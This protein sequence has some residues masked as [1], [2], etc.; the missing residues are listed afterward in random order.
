[1]TTAGLRGVGD[2]WLAG[3][4]VPGVEFAL[5]DRVE[6]TAGRHAGALG[7]VALLTLLHPEP[8]Y[9]VALGDGTSVRARQSA[10]RAAS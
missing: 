6:I 9:L 7:G 10:L 5:H 1:M 2:R 4:P 8:A 3:E